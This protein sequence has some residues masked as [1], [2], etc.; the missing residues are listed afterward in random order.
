MNKNTVSGIFGILAGTITFF[1]TK[2]VWVAV[3]A[4]IFALFL[5]MALRPIFPNLF[6]NKKKDGPA[7]IS[8]LRERGFE[9]GAPEQRVMYALLITQ[10]VTPDVNDEAQRAVLEEIY[11]KSIAYMTENFD[12]FR[13]RYQILQDRQLPLKICCGTCT[14]K[15]STVGKCYRDFLKTVHIDNNT[16]MGKENIDLFFHDLEFT[17]KDGITRNAVT[18]V[19]FY[20]W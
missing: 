15:K 6:E 5:A 1:T 8:V 3:A 19:Q 9:D 4:F 16:Y 18:A 20:R 14:E 2:N 17:D 7:T 12:F 10:D 11:E 13:S